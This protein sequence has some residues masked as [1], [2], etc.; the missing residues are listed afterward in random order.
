M[1]TLGK[2][3]R[4]LSDEALSALRDNGGVAQMVA[5]DYYL[6][7]LCGNG[8]EER[9][10][11]AVSQVDS[12]NSRPAITC[13]RRGPG[14]MGGWSPWHSVG[15]QL[16]LISSF[17]FISTDLGMLS[18]SLTISCTCSPRFGLRSIPAFFASFT[19]SGSLY[20]FS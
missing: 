13:G 20:D 1:L 2:V 12:G 15:C 16:L 19:R 5:F 3:P 7:S 9:A 10:Q 4:N 18:S 17:I 11:P 14:T 6:R 8:P